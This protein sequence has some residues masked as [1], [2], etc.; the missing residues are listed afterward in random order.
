M[1]KS[2][3]A[4]FALVAPVIAMFVITD[5]GFT[6]TLIWLLNDNATSEDIISMGFEP[7]T[8]WPLGLYFVLMVAAC[9]AF[10]RSEKVTL[11][12]GVE[13]GALALSV[14]ALGLYVTDV[15]RL[16]LFFHRYGFIGKALTMFALSGTVALVVRIKPW[17]K[18]QQKDEGVTLM[19]PLMAVL[20]CFA[21]LWFSCL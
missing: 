11:T 20:F 14:V 1:K 2:P 18:Y 10:S 12:H 7:P 19:H 5:N 9:V 16:D 13:W 17:D 3:Y 4:M 21:L 8:F 15:E 6:H